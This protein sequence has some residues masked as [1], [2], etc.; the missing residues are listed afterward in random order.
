MRPE[1]NSTGSVLETLVQSSAQH[2]PGLVVHLG[3]RDMGVTNS[4]SSAVLWTEEN[5][6]TRDPASK[7][8]W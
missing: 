6:V 5:P 8:R 1:I 7:Q 3:R 4:R 2:V